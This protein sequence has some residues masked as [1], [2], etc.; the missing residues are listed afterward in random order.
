MEQKENCGKFDLA[1]KISESPIH[2]LRRNHS[3]AV[4]A[5]AEDSCVDNRFRCSCRMTVYS[6]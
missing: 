4:T 2:I 5:S 6:Q 3:L 1:E